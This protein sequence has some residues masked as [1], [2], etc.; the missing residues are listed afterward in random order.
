MVD[1]ETK[2]SARLMAEEFTKEFTR[3]FGVIPT[4]TY[5]FAHPSIKGLTINDF[6]T[7]ANKCFL[8]HRVYAPKIPLN[9]TRRFNEL[10]AFRQAFA[11]IAHK[12]GFPDKVI[13]ATLGRTRTT[14]VIAR[15][16]FTRLREVHDPQTIKIYNILVD[17]IDKYLYTRES[18]ETDDTHGEIF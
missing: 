13:A 11:F 4:V 14:I 1:E 7:V 10:A 15:Q 5:D 2:M 8:K 18:L 9:S 3:R 16:T 12:H 17:S 6:Y